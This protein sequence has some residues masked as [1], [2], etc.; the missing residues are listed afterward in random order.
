MDEINRRGFIGKISALVG[1]SVATFRNKTALEASQ[2]GQSSDEN[3]GGCSFLEKDIGPTIRIGAV[4]IHDAEIAKALRE[5]RLSLLHCKVEHHPSGG[6]YVEVSDGS[7]VDNCFL[8]CLGMKASP[9]GLC[10]NNTSMNA[11]MYGMISNGGH[12][13]NNAAFAP[14]AGGISSGTHPGGKTDSCRV[15]FSGS[16]SHWTGN[17][18]VNNAGSGVAVMGAGMTGLKS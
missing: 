9:G 8:N 7:F 6:D 4:V 18:F 10:K 15:I 12:L 5:G 13:L 16:Y 2:E 17:R 3:S 11:P 14:C 1:L